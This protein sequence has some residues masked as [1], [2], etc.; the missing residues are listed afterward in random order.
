MA[1]VP[2]DPIPVTG[3]AELL[4]L[5]AL[6][7]AGELEGKAVGRPVGSV[8][9]LEVWGCPGEWNCLQPPQEPQGKVPRERLSQCPVSLHFGQGR[10]GIWTP[11]THQ[12][13]L[14]GG[15]DKS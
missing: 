2:T 12:H 3:P 13:C 4:W 11:K 1:S 9:V 8:G 15:R 14:R 6:E 7:A 10:A 5:R